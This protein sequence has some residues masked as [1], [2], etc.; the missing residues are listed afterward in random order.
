MKLE[1][2]FGVSNYNLS[3]YIERKE[4]DDCFENALTK[5]TTSHLWLFKTR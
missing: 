2:V 1:E 3:T 5:K 4:I